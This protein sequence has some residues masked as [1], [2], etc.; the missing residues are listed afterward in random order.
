MR[1]NNKNSEK[2]IIKFVRFLLRLYTIIRIL[3]DIFGG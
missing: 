2:R 1:K 3:F